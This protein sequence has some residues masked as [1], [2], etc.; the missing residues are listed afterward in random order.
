MCERVFVSLTRSWS[1]ANH[2]NFAMKTTT[3][4]CCLLLTD[5]SGS[6]INQ[7]TNHFHLRSRAIVAAALGGMRLHLVFSRAC[8]PVS[9]KRRGSRIPT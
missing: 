7:G 9:M 6:S 2:N 8:D 3:V 1:H 4:Y 5:R